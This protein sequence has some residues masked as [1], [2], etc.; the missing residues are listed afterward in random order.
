MEQ[1]KLFLELPPE[2]EKYL[3]QHRTNLTQ[4]LKDEGV[5]VSERHEISPFKAGGDDDGHVAQR[6][7][8]LVLVS[9]AGAAVVISALG[10]AVNNIL[11]TM[12]K[13]PTMRIAYRRRIVKDEQGNVV[14]NSK[15][16]PIYE[17]DEMPVMLEPRAE[18]SSVGMQFQAG[19]DISLV[20]GAT[21][22]ENP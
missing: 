2:V 3:G 12:N 20:I 9:T 13:K 4:L 18:N 8:C 1:T 10:I 7:I 16:N 5:T 14:F 19:E 11:K 6:D 15:G 17:T 21:H 22:Q